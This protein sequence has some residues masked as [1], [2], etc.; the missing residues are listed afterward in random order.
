VYLFDSFFLIDLYEKH[1]SSLIS[2]I[3]RL[4]GCRETAAD[5]AQEASIYDYLFT[6]MKRVFLILKPI[7]SGSDVTWQLIT[8]AVHSAKPNF[9]RSTKSCFALRSHPMSWLVF[10]NNV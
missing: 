4:T 3:A 6:V 9:Y 7:C 2:S 8:S 10:A 5:L 1:R